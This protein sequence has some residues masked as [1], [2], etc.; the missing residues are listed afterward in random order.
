[1]LWTQTN[2][3]LCALAQMAP[4]SQTTLVSGLGYA[5][6]QATGRPPDDLCYRQRPRYLPDHGSNCCRLIKPKPFRP[7]RAFQNVQT[8]GPGP[9]NR[10]SGL[11][12][13]PCTDEMSLACHD[14]RGSHQGGFWV[15]FG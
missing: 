14:V 11:Q 13:F 9:L 2:P 4:R 8:P 6:A 10:R 12:L 1:M 15:P 5:I 7:G 3:G